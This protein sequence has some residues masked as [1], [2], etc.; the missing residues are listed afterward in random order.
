MESS[1][2]RKSR[3]FDSAGVGSGPSTPRATMGWPSAA[4]IGVVALSTSPQSRVTLLL[5][6]RIESIER[7]SGRGAARRF[8]LRGQ[9]QRRVGNGAANRRA[10]FV[11]ELRQRRERGEVA[12]PN[13]GD[14]GS[15]S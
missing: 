5:L 15:V 11:V 4:T 12:G 14:G 1:S 13:F 7:R 6:A 10:L 3:C 9:V 2:S 8:D